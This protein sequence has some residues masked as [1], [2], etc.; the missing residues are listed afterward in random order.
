MLV[1]IYIVEWLFS[2]HYLRGEAMLAEYPL[3]S[4]AGVR[5]AR[6]WAHGRNPGFYNFDAIGGDCTSFVSQC[7]L[8]CGAVMN[9]TPD[10]GWYYLSLSDRAAAWTGVE[11]FYIF[12]ISNRSAGPFGEEVPIARA[13]V[14]DVIQLGGSGG[15]Y[16]SLFV[17][18]IR[19]GEP[20]ICAHTA[21]AHDRPLS[22]YDG[23][24]M[25]CI[26]L[27]GARKYV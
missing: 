9:Y 8:A 5:Y 19:N 27:L 17:T 22:Y 11:Y 20:L 15:Y 14:G 16:H 2:A 24:R 4:T 12:V 6:R 25:R 26:H 7:V 3:D 1:N 23:A 13:A 18:E 10:T 21:D